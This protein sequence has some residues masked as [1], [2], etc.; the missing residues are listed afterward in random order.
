MS[1]TK[2]RTGLTLGALVAIGAG[3][4]IGP[5]AI[6][7]PGSAIAMTGRSAGFAFFTAVIVGFITI[8]PW[9]LT[10]GVIRAKGGDYTLITCLLGPKAGGVVLWNMFIMVIAVSLMGLSAGEYLAVFFPNVNAQLVGIIV[11]TLF[12]VLNMFGVGNMS[13]LQNLMFYIMLAGFAVFLAYGL[14]NL[15]PGTFNLADPE[16]YP[17]GISGFSSAVLVLLYGCTAA[18]CLIY[19]GRDAQDARR[20]IPRAMLI[21]TGI[22]LVLYTLTGIVASNVLP[23]EQVAGKTIAEVALALMPYPVFVF[24]MI[25]CPFFALFTTLNTIFISNAQNF[26]QGAKDGWLPKAFAKTNRFGAPV[27]CMTLLYAITMIP[28]LLGMDIAQMSANTALVQYIMR[29][30]T[31]A[32]VWRLPKKLPDLWKKSRFYMPPVLF[33]AVMIL[34]TLTDLAVVYTSVM[35][36]TPT[37][38]LISLAAMAVCTAIP[39]W[40]NHRGLVHVD[41]DPSNYL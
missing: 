12:F 15:R 32:A 3:M 33:H 10:A 5:G 31:V 8:L 40:R 17:N 26:L 18:Q 35:T 21:T 4:A 1:D 27:L 34:I 9:F 2:K 14:P 39:L 7:L 22:I 41:M 19:F 30:V 28:Q 36:L 25:A 38:V 13:K 6:S 24:F 37:I 20:D 29:F 16:F 23:V 11:V